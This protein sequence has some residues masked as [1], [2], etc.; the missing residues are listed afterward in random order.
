MAFFNPKESECVL[1]HEVAGFHDQGK[2]R[3]RLQRA[4]MALTRFMKFTELSCP[5]GFRTFCPLGS[6]NW[7][8]ETAMV[9]EDVVACCFPSTRNAPVW[10]VM[11]SRCEKL[12][13]LSSVDNR[14]MAS[15]MNIGDAFNREPWNGF[16]KASVEQGRRL[17]HN[18]LK[19]VCSLRSRHCG[20]VERLVAAHQDGIEVYRS[21]RHSPQPNSDEWLDAHSTHAVGA[22]VPLHT[23]VRLKAAADEQIRHVSGGWGR[24]RGF[25]RVPVRRV[26]SMRTPGSW[27]GIH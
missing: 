17:G 9:D 10:R 23:M 25:L 6:V 15:P 11:P 18:V 3:V 24:G 20:P 5:R 13:V 27:S 7:V 2:P 26:R 1:G 22:N 16:F 21:L 12:L 19:I 4:S 8:D 14:G